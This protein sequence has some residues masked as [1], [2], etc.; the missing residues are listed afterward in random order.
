[1]AGK[2]YYFGVWADPD[3]AEQE[4]KK[5]FPYRRI[6]LD[7][8]ADQMTLKEVLNHWA[9]ASKKR[10]P[11]RRSMIGILFHARMLLRHPDAP[12]KKSA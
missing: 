5:Q 10:S 4:F 7:P 1:V 11:A 8:S 6:G 9:M 3:A 12:V 2:R